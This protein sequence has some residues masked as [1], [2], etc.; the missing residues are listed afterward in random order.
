MC[1]IFVNYAILILQDACTYNIF[2]QGNNQI[3]TPKFIHIY[4]RNIK[5]NRTFYYLKCTPNKQARN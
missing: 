5:A 2:I 3:T 1:Y 4:T